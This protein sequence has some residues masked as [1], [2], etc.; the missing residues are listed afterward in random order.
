MREVGIRDVGFLQR[1]GLLPRCLDVDLCQS[2]YDVACGAQ[3]I[4]MD[5]DE[6]RLSLNLRLIRRYWHCSWNICRN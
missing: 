1:F 2:T 6:V 4:I 3:L 5:E